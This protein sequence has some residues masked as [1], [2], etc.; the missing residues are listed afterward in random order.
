MGERK[1]KKKAVVHT[2]TSSSLLLMPQALLKHESFTLA[3]KMTTA[4][5]KSSIRLL[6][7]TLMNRG[8]E[9]LL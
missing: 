5:T 6:I 4:S 1:K 8:K 3:S 2:P 9:C 7:T